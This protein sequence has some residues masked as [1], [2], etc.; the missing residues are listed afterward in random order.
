[1]HRS[2]VCLIGTNSKTVVPKHNYI[3]HT[4]HHGGG[5]N[6]MSVSELHESIHS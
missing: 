2:M 5:L 6:I 3:V 4:G 1:M